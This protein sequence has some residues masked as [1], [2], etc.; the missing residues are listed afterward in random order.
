MRRL[1][2][3]LS[4]PELEREGLVGA[5]RLRLDM[6]ENRSGVEARLH[7]DDLPPLPGKVSEGLYRIA[8]E[9]LNNTLKHAQADTVTIQLGFEGEVVTLAVIDDGQG[10]DPNAVQNGGLGL[11][12]MQGRADSLGADLSIDSAPDQ[13]TTVRVSLGVRGKMENPQ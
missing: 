13:G 4:P 2:F 11:T 3:E 5:L 8:L 7:A 9:A 1:V 10:F 6:V 12:S